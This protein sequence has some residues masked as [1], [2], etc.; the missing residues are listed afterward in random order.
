MN[1]TGRSR[2]AAVLRTVAVTTGEPA[3]IGPDLCT[4]LLDTAPPGCRVV[5][6]GDRSLF[7]MLRDFPHVLVLSAHS[8]AQ[9]HVF[10]DASSGWQGA[11][12]LH[13]YNVGA[14]CGGYWSGVKDADGIPDSRMSD[15]T[16]N[17]YASARFAADGSMLIADYSGHHV[18]RIAAGTREAKVFASDFKCSGI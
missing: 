14:A 8:H 5:L 16:P 10:H 6:I 4:E 7:A 17:G 9:R 18:L 13:E 2:R 12:P 1:T 11:A 3:G 15:G